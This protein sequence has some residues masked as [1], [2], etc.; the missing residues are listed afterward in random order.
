[1]EESR[2]GWIAIFPCQWGEGGS[3][4]SLMITW[5]E[6]NNVFISFNSGHCTATALVYR[7]TVTVTLYTSLG[8]EGPSVV[9]WSL[10][11]RHDGPEL[12]PQTEPV[13]TVN[14]PPYHAGPV[15]RSASNHVP[16]LARPLLLSS[17]QLH[18]VVFWSRLVELHKIKHPA[19]PPSLATANITQ[20][21]SLLN[22]CQW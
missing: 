2:E 15:R 10:T 13:S 7:V 12:S 19:C 17:G 22:C 3:G 5:W 16:G 1:M 6:E 14:Y 4:E 9:D 18:S 20:S 21:V 8:W 11:R